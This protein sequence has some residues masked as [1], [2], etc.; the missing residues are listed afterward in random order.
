MENFKTGLSESDKQIL[1]SIFPL[2]IIVVLI[3]VVGKFG[4]SQIGNVRKN[5]SDLNKTELTLTEKL[6]ILKTVSQLSDTGSTAAVTALPEA[7]ASLS[8]LSQIRTIAAKENLTISEIKSSG[9]DSSGGD[10]IFSTSIS[11]T[12]AGTRES[13]I[14]F[15]KAIDT[16]APLTFVNGFDL[17]ESGSASTANISLKTYYAP[18]PSTIPTVTQAVTDLSE[19]DKKILS[20]LG[21][22][23]PPS[24]G[25]ALTPSTVENLS[26]FGE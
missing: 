21:T 22:L 19:S 7:N 3:F 8:V 12:L 6:N 24:I 15:V 9:A 16:I 25:E 17:S 4:I 23:T 26:P 20:D 5:I 18:L 11:F 13:I 1:K 14:S 10:N 2:V